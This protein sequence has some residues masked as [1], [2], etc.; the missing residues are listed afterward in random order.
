MKEKFLFFKNKSDEKLAGILHLPKKK[1]KE[2]IILCHGFGSSKSARKFTILARYLC[3]KGFAVFR[4]DFSG[5]GDSE[6]DFK[7]FSLKT[8][9][10]DL[11][12]ALEIF[13]KEAQPEKISFLGH[14]LG[15]LVVS[16]FE[17][18]KHVAKALILAAPAIDQKNL[19]KIWYKKEEIEKWEK[20][21]FI[22][23]DKGRIGS[24]Y[25]EDI[26]KDYTEILPEIFCP[27]LV[28]GG[29]RDDKVPES[30]SK[31]VYQKLSSKKK[32]FVL[33]DT[34]HHFENEEGKEVLKKEI[35]EWLKIA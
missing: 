15:A 10:K 18:E 25:L 3:Q 31:R 2:G 35:L 24:K 32:K 5:H 26:K 34:D 6:G 28:L 17:K 30:F 29:K 13:K 11:F 23:T 16:L 14:S 19:S 20:D 9:K 33:V 8:L 22:D 21:G 1:R 7:E 4:F 12:C 27:T